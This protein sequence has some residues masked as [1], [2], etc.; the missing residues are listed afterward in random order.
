MDSI[1]E[2]LLSGNKKDILNYLDTKNLQN[3]NI[4]KFED[5]YWLFKDKD[6]YLSAIQILRNRLIFD[7]V[8]WSFSIYNGLK[9]EFFEYI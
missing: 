7:E 6:F 5:I 4:F 2:I 1:S 8:S 3:R 9:Q